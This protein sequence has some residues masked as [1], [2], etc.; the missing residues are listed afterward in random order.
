LE[1]ID[2]AVILKNLKSLRRDSSGSTLIVFATSLPLL[3]AG[4]GAAMMYGF[5]VT[6]VSDMQAALD[7]GTLAGTA[8]S[9]SA[10]PDTRLENANS[11]YAWNFVAKKG[12]VKTTSNFWVQGGND[13][14]FIA[15][16]WEVSGT[17]SAKVRNPFSF[18]IGNEWLPVT[19]YSTATKLESD[20]VCLL[21]LNSTMDAAIGFNGQP[22]VTVKGCA[23]QANSSSDEA[24][25]QKGKPLMSASMIGTTGGYTGTG[26]DPIPMTGTIPLDDPYAEVP[27][28]S[29]APCNYNSV[30]IIKQ[31]VTLNPGVYC[32]GLAVKAGSLVR[33]KPGIYVMRDGPLW[34]N[35]GADLSGEE[36]MIGFT[37]PGASIRMD[38][39]SQAR[40]TSPAGGTY[41]NMQFMQEPGTGG[42]DIA[43]SITGNNKL[44]YDG[45]MYFPSQDIELGGGS[46]IEVK[47]PSYA[48][49]ADTILIRDHSVVTVSHENTRDLPVADA[50]G[51]KYGARLIR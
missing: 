19:A 50:N 4:S 20:P 9:G 17:A 5:Q 18:L 49:V 2:R 34:V 51:Y 6:T 1:K 45:V 48:M 36:V 28:P 13:P 16:K 21:A 26:Y 12:S 42:D 46:V 32:G 35:S 15:N 39:S 7:S 29:S 25:R 11:A 33:L 27:F 44:S 40:L 8:M 43:V 14:E 47:S 22:K 23:A 41:M 10:T 30:K 38:G 31:T 37:G 24:I 3:L